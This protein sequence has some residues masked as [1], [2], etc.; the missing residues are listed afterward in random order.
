MS[1]QKIALIVLVA[2]F[3]CSLFYGLT[4]MPEQKTVARLTNLPGMA[5][6][7]QKKGQQQVQTAD[8]TRVQL[9]LFD[10]KSSGS[11]GA[12]RNIFKPLFSGSANMPPLPPPPPLPEETVKAA[13]VAPP[14]PPPVSAPE[15]T[16]VQRDMAK[17][18]FLGFLKKDNIKTIFL[19]KDKEIFLAKRGD[20]IAGKYEVA[21]IT[22]DALMISILPDGGEI[23]IPLVE[24]R[25][26]SA[27]RR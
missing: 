22:D 25:S 2:G 17:F 15:P 27:P 9:E 3:A 5:A 1:R 13:P 14:P 8:G 11:Y 16:P 20:K 6:K 21:N 19:S 7:V 24:N 26:L 23:I 18:T 4:H 10:R 12:S